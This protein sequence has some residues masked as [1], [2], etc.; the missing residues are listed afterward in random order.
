MSPSQLKQQLQQLILVLRVAALIRIDFYLTE[1]GLSLRG[2]EPY[3][4]LVGKMA[5]GV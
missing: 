2:D 1:N 3:D 5:R 4:E